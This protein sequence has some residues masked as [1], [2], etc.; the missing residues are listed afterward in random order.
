[1]IHIKATAELHPHHTHIY[2]G[3][4]MYTLRIRVEHDREYVTVD[5]EVSDVDLFECGYAELVVEHATRDLLRCIAKARKDR[6]KEEE[7]E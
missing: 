6:L 4:A 1:M 2:S 7:D 3:H 5:K